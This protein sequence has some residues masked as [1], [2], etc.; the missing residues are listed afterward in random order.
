MSRTV[1]SAFE[2]EFTRYRELAERAAGH[3]PWP[4]WREALD[5]ETNSIAV[6]MKHVGGNLRSRWTDPFTTDGEKPWRERDREFIDDVRD[7]QGL[8]AIWN[9]GWDALA[10]SLGA[11]ADADLPRTLLIRTE[12]HTLAL[13]LA[14]SCTHI[15]Y[16]AGQ[17]VQAARVIASRT[18]VPWT[19]L[20]IPR[21]G[22]AAFNALKGL[23]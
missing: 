22:S 14:R 17:I 1:I 21:G 15:A 20:T 19:T 10:G 3:L 2:A 23:G 4:G 13:A 12:P 7:Q 5:P 16:H 11:M 8:L 9:A 18:G 6:I